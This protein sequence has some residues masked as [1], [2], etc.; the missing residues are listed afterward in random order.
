VN[1]AVIGLQESRRFEEQRSAARELAA[2]L[3]AMTRL[4]EFGSLLLTNTELPTIFEAALD[5]TI[6]LQRAE[7]GMAQLF[8]ASKGDFYIVAQRGF[9]PAFLSLFRD[10]L[11][12]RTACGRAV[13]ERARV[14]IED[15]ELDEVFAPLREAA[16]QAGFRAVQSTPLFARD[17][18]VLGV[19]STHFRDPHRPSERDLRRQRR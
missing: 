1:Q 11:D 3:E 4:H 8:N 10:T 12:P 15:V 13:L 5:A 18:E 9:G 16:R 6:A 14:V 17:G 7:L 2:E 19:I